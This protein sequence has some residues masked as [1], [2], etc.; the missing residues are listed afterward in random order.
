MGIL[1]GKTVLVT[2]G[3]TREYLDPSRYISKPSS[4]KLGYAITEACLGL[5]AKVSLV[6]G[7]VTLECPTCHLSPLGPFPH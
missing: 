4:G 1:G 6:S 3:P 5:G 7:P 2:A